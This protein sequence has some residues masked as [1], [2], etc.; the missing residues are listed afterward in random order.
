M[1]GTKGIC[2][3]P[4]ARAKLVHRRRAERQRKAASPFSSCAHLFVALTNK[5]SIQ[6]SCLNVNQAETSMDQKKSKY[7]I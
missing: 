7:Q 5:F 2:Q 1:Q 3:E 6:S 4:K